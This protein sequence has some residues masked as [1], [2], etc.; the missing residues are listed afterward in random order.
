MRCAIGIDFGGTNLKG[1]VVSECGK[2][3]LKHKGR[4]TRGERPGAEIGADLAKIAEDLAKK[5]PHAEAVGIGTPGIVLPSGKFGFPPCNCPNFGNA[6]LKKIVEGHVGKPAFINNDAQVFSTAEMMWGAGK[7]AKCMLMLTLGTGIGGGLCVNG[8]DFQGACNTIEIG[9]ICVNFLPD[10]PLCG[11]G[12]RGC[13]ETYASDTGISRQAQDAIDRGLLPKAKGGPSAGV[14]VR[15]RQEGQLGR[16]GHHQHRARGAGDADRRL[17]QR[18][19]RGRL[20]AR[21]RHHGRGR[22]PVRR[23]APARRRAHDPHR[24]GRHPALRTRRKLQRPRRC[25]VRVQQAG[26]V[27]A[28]VQKQDG[29]VRVDGHTDDAPRC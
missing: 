5:H 25:R 21:R 1:G 24:Q 16:R 7:G 12:Q 29:L 18:V 3:L 9:H 13:A 17:R 11:C 6:N 19:E 8:Q 20:R 22:L 10:A 14:G 28:F 23:R 2:V 15:P 4:K 26:R 27:T